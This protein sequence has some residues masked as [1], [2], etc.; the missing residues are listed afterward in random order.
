MT[1][2]D[3]IFSL[4]SK[5]KEVTALPGR[6]VS[7]SQRRVVYSPA[8]R[9][10]IIAVSPQPGTLELTPF[11]ETVNIGVPGKTPTFVP[12]S[13]SAREAIGFVC[14]G[15]EDNVQR[16][17]YNLMR[18]ITP[19]LLRTAGGVP[20]GGGRYDLKNDVA[21]DFRWFG[22]RVGKHDVTRAHRPGV[23]LIPFSTVEKIMDMAGYSR[24]GWPSIIDIAGY[25]YSARDGSY[26]P[27]I[28]G[29]DVSRGEFF[30]SPEAAIDIRARYDFLKRAYATYYKAH[31]LSTAGIR[32]ATPAYEIVLEFLR[33]NG[34]T[35]PRGYLRSMFP[36]TKGAWLPLESQQVS[37]WTLPTKYAIWRGVVDRKR[38]HLNFADWLKSVYL[39][40]VD[41]CRLDGLQSK[42]M[43]MATESKFKVKPGRYLAV[44]TWG[45]FPVRW[46][47]GRNRA[48]GTTQYQR[49]TW[50]QSGFIGAK[51][52]TIEPGKTT[53]F[54]PTIAHKIRVHPPIERP[55]AWVLAFERHM[56]KRMWGSVISDLSTD[57]QAML[58]D[59][60]DLV[61]ADLAGYLSDT[62]ALIER[63]VSYGKQLKDNGEAVV[64][65]FRR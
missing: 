26:L 11:R 15:F 31:G 51:A 12:D 25:I 33:A 8:A 60:V 38:P 29:V 55:G 65:L 19:A 47:S 16:T 10:G 37:S 13:Q 4:F 20:P 2:L 63:G 1:F 14:G 35:D 22:Y 34:H 17:S 24:S 39:P 21:F 44:P 50:E 58:P 43:P 62:A 9:P 46:F 56:I 27:K 42:N 7:M 59:L 45:S 32:Y 61:P 6:L 23:E 41:N 52:I 40:W 57:L 5:K 54:D 48:R 49:W 36:A 53:R 30:P 64:D 3:F 18:V 28:K